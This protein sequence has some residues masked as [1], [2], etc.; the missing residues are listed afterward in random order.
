MFILAITYCAYGINFVLTSFLVR[1]CGPIS[2][3][4][5][6]KWEGY[7]LVNWYYGLYSWRF[8]GNLGC[9]S[10]GYP[11]SFCIHRLECALASEWMFES[12]L[13]SDFG[14]NRL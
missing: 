8:C 3:L 14:H 12:V 9:S 2:G 4:I 10:L 13:S 11:N 6:Y 7:L 1:G 5:N